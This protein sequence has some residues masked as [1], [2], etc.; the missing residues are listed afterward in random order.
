MA[1]AGEGASIGTRM[2]ADA[3]CRLGRH[4]GKRAGR[5]LSPDSESIRSH[6]TRNQQTISCFAEREQELK[7]ARMEE[8]HKV[9]S[10]ASLISGLVKSKPL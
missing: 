9:L 5:S 3:Q 6:G 1:A 2:R 7:E 8:K 10:K 4:G